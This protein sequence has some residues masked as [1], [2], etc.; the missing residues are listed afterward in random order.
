VLQSGLPDE[1]VR[2]PGTRR[3]AELVGYLGFVP[4]TAVPL[5]TGGSDGYRLADRGEA[6]QGER[7]TAGI[8][9][10]R[11]L[12]GAAPDLGVVLRGPLTASR[13]AGAGW[14]ADILCAGTTVTV[15]LPD[16]PVTD[17]GELTV[18]ATGAPV[19]GTDDVAV[20]LVGAGAETAGADGPASPV[21]GGSAAG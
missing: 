21:T 15:R 16:R 3:V 18:T 9:P 1:V 19:F 14:E 10:D 20:A 5:T 2:Q 8:H 17:G 6:A 4:V 11:V 13:P 12:P 7:L